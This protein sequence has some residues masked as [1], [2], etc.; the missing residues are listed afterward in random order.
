MLSSISLYNL[1][2]HRST[3]CDKD[4]YNSVTYK[5]IAVNL[6]TFCSFQVLRYKYKIVHQY[7]KCSY[8]YYCAWKKYM[9]H[10]NLNILSELRYTCTCIHVHLL[11]FH[12]HSWQCLS[13]SDW[14]TIE[15]HTHWDNLKW[16]TLR[17][18]LPFQPNT[19]QF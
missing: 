6:Y 8:G 11:F 19:K 9:H 4:L 16:C 17:P 3:I 18:P 2:N 15:L 1:L 12:R 14:Y 5:Q 10:L 13:Y 7:I